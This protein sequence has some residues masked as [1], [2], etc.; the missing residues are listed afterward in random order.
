MRCRFCGH[1]I[2]CE[3]LDLGNSPPSNSF[4]TREELNHPEIF[5]PLKLFFCPKC[6]LVQMEEVR[7]PEDI[8][9][10][11][12]VYYSS[13]SKSWVEYARKY[14]DAVADRFGLDEK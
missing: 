9:T 11:D 14:V 8:F 6:G 12:Y 13:V 10:G 2:E 1:G 5:Y 4:L 7:K 3:F